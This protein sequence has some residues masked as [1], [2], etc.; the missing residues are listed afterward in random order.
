[1]TS[2][3]QTDRQTDTLNAILHPPTGDKV[4]AIS[5]VYKTLEMTWMNQ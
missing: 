1:M 4:R 5:H 3:R 2:D